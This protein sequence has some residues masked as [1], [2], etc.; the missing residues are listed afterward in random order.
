MRKKPGALSPVSFSPV[1]A[2]SMDHDEHSVSASFFL[3]WVGVGLGL[4]AERKE[5][6]RKPLPTA[7]PDRQPDTS[8]TCLC[9]RM[10]SDSLRGW[11]D[12]VARRRPPRLCP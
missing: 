8:R 11:V 5:V 3:C 2:Q 10:V 7:G 9:V 1:L 12:Q 6:W 4:M